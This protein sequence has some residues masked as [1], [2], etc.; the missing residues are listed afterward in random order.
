MKGVRAGT[1]KVDYH[2]VFPRAPAEENSA[3]LKGGKARLH[4]SVDVG[5][6][7]TLPSE[8]AHVLHFGLAV[9]G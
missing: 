1:A 4:N 7:Q 9:S 8:G 2:P 3:I 5:G 6:N